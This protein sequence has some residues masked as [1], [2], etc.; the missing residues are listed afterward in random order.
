MTEIRINYKETKNAV[1]EVIFTLKD[2]QAEAA[3]L[4]IRL[5][6]WRMNCRR[7]PRIQRKRNKEKYMIAMKSRE[8]RSNIRTIDFFIKKNK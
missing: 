2:L 7:S 3:L 8:Q 1:A 6:M 5:V 4:K